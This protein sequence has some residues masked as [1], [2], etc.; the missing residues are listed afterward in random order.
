MYHSSEDLFETQHKT[1][2]FQEKSGG[3][4]NVSKEK[5]ERKS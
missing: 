1:L 3:V 5:S 2:K 4:R